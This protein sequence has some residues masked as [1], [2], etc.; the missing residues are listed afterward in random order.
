SWT[1]PMQ[2]GLRRPLG[3]KRR[4]PSESSSERSWKG[5]LTPCAPS[6]IRSAR[7]LASGSR[8]ISI[9]RCSRLPG[10]RTCEGGR[11]PLSAFDRDPL[12]P[13]EVEVIRLLPFDLQAKL[14]SF[15]DALQ[16]R[17][18]RFRLGVA[19]AK[20]RNRRYAVAGTVTLDD[21]VELSHPPIL[22]ILCA[23]A[24]EEKSQ[25]R[26]V[27]ALVPPPA[28]LRRSVAEAAPAGAGLVCRL[29]LME[30]GEAVG[31]GR[32]SWLPE[33]HHVSGR[34]AIQDRGDV[35]GHLV[36]G[37]TDRRVRQV[38]IAGRRLRPGVSEQRADDLQRGPQACRRGRVCVTKVMQADALQSRA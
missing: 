19:P 3:S 23:A 38:G 31:A 30:P 6:W 15:P 12:D 5:R 29:S 14:N 37:G 10:N 32:V 20:R 9:R 27:A 11:S 4:A 36:G 8:T 28:A 16:E 25:V 13:D 17:I 7:K 26:L 24:V 33:R 21:D 2:G 1:S 22:Q 35:V 18:Q 34:L